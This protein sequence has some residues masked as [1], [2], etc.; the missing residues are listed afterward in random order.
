[1]VKKMR[2]W[3]T[4]AGEATPTPFCECRICQNAR[5][6]GGRELRLRSSFRIDEKTIIDVGADFAAEAQNMGESLYDIENILYTHTHEDHFNYMVLWTRSVARKKPDKPMNVYFSEDAYSVI[7]KFIMT[8]P[9]TEGRESYTGPDNVNFVKLE[10]GNEYEIGNLKVTPLRG[11]HR[12]VFE[13]NSA[14]YLITLPNGK[15]MYYALDSGYY[16][17]ET[18]E[19]LKDRKIDLLISEC[20]MPILEDDGKNCPWHMTLH[21]ALRT[22][23]R[24]YEQG[25]ISDTTEVWFTHIAPIG[26][27]H[28]ELV[29]YISGLTLPYKLNVAYDG[30]SLEDRFGF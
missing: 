25:T 21:T 15:T 13:K 17:E 30:L 16:L 10:F 20:T 24:L 19:A 26:S 11:N 4:S 7:E 1:M 27:T 6:K 5:E 8:S 22:F 28:A 9:V 3:G 14:N 2:F 18:F 29:D 12:T 23:E